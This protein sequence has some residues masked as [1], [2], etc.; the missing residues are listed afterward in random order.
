MD[1]VEYKG[2]NEQPAVRTTIVGGRPPGPGKGVG[3]VPRGIEVLVKKAAVDPEFRAMLLSERSAGAAEIG[4]ELSDAEAAML[5]GVPE[6]QLERI[7]A[8]T[9]VSLKLRPAFMGRAAVVMLA[10]L[11]VV[12]AS[13]CASTFGSQPDDPGDWPPITGPEPEDRVTEPDGNDESTS[14]DQSEATAIYDRAA[15]IRPDLPPIEPEDVA[16]NDG[17][18]VNKQ[19][20]LLSISGDGE[21]EISDGKVIIHSTPDDPDAAETADE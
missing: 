9:T 16:N 11:G 5:D 8:N 7:I 21:Y 6:T 2:N 12:T 3:S 14:G 1:T 18:P 20:E 19:P 15:G 13:G 17:E 4:L 10:A